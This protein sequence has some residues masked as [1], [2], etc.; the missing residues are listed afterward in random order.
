MCFTQL[1]LE[2]DASCKFSFSSTKKLSSFFKLK[3]SF[4]WYFV[5]SST[6]DKEH[7]EFGDVLIEKVVLSPG[8]T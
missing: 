2:E 8:W 5:A 3:F 6:M 7:R 4:E 1:I